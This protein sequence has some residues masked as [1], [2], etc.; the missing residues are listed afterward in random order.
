MQWVFG[1]TSRL[2]LSRIGRWF[3]VG[4]GVFSL[5]FMPLLVIK[6]QAND[7]KSSNKEQ[8]NIYCPSCRNFG[9]GQD[10][11]YN[12]NS[13]VGL[14]I[15]GGQNAIFAS[16]APTADSAVISATSTTSAPALYANNNQGGLAFRFD[17]NGIM[18]G[19]LSTTNLA[20]SGA[21]TLNGNVSI[22]GVLNLNGG[23]NLSNFNG[24]LSLNAQVN[25]DS[26]IKGA[27]TATDAIATGIYG[28]APNGRGVIGA[29][30][31]GNGVYA[32]S[33]GT[34]PAL[35][36][37]NQNGPAFQFGGNGTITAN[38]AANPALA[39]NNSSGAGLQVTGNTS[40]TASNGTVLNVQGSAAKG[41]V[42][43]NSSGVA[44][45][46]DSDTGVAVYGYSTQYNGVVAQNNTAN[47]PALYAKNGGGGVAA[48]LDGDTVV[49]GNLTVTG[50]KS[51]YVVDIALNDS[52]E[53]IE[54]GDVVV[55]TGFAPAVVGNIPVPKIR[56]AN[57]AYTSGVV[58][59][60]DQHYNAGSLA[61]EKIQPGQYL[62]MVT[63]GAFRSIKVDT[64]NGP[65]VPGDLL[66]ASGTHPG[67]AMKASL[68]TS[69]NGIPIAPVGV[70]GKALDGFNND[71]GTI[72][73]LVTLK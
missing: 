5:L 58:G 11:I 19:A 42:A 56:K 50:S 31:N 22:G 57:Q 13:N 34:Q 12:G 66:V 39:I 62:S 33:N 4:V 67:F 28:Y 35:Y 23:L 44:L 51:G 53:T 54:A 59:I 40:L 49:K 9:Y 8:S 45:E 16:S 24:P 71:I 7:P 68:A 10:W 60:V 3:L 41:V 37:I 73:V 52:Q 15:T 61:L 32:M 17:G 65:I 69:N 18:N 1:A 63:L 36:A 38:S 70:V 27:N 25:G 47:Y 48:Q 72:P 43:N 64:S 21:T 46:G 2:G 30:Q 6:V 29:S 26:V 55:V 14:I 20:V